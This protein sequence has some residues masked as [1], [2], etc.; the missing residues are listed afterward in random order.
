MS[1]LLKRVRQYMV[2]IVVVVTIYTGRTI[3]VIIIL[4][5]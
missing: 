5:G 1:F 2:T 4:R 3:S